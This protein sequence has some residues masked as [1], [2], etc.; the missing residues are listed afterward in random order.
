MNHENHPEAAAAPSPAP[1][2]DTSKHPRRPLPRRAPGR[3]WAVAGVLG[4]VAAVAAYLVMPGK[5]PEPSGAP[6]FTGAPGIADSVSATIEGREYRVQG[7]S[8]LEIDG[9]ETRSLSGGTA[10]G[11]KRVSA[12]TPFETGS[13]FKVF[14]AMT[15]ADLAADGRTSLDRTLGE[16]FPDLAFASPEFADIT[17]EQ[18]ASHRSGLPRMPAEGLAA[19]AVTPFTL[20]D[21]YGGLP[22][23]RDSLAAAVPLPGQPAWQYSNFGFAVLGAALA[24]ETGTPFPQ[25]VRERIFDPLGMDDTVMRGAGL[26]GL[27]EGAA[28]PHATPG[29]PVEPWKAEPYIPAGVGTWTTAADLERFLRAVMDG[30]APGMSATEP[31]HG[32]PVDETRIG[33]AWLT[34]DF[35]DGVELVQHSGATYGSTAFIGFQ[36]DRGAIVLSNSFTAEASL[37]GPRLLGAPDV[38]PM[39]E[40]PTATSVAAGLGATLP[41]AV[42]PPL[43]AVTLMLRRRTLVGQRPLDRLRVVSM[44]AGTSATLLGALVIG[45]W[46]ATP[47]AVWAA[48]VG[49]LVAAA[50]VGA[51]YWPRIPTEA[52]R[53][54]WLHIAFFCLSVCVSGVVAVTAANSLVAVFG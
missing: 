12:E 40:S 41:F 33:L 19:G 22:P 9:G 15:L 13:V 23:V 2:P 24:E 34:T 6:E 42:L 18:L 3:V 7:L 53:W 28:L 44:S 27:P 37:I 16:V 39:A 14:T 30:S 21:P 29:K 1:P 4:A 5:P 48:A 35:G 10:D 43:L 47:P 17:L 11:E 36:G 45:D 20:T 52:G 38:P 32:G 26:A 46:V 51:W 25:L 54:R 8:V 31:A 50:A 49:A